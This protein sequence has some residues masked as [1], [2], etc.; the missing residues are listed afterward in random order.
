MM[1]PL[2]RGVSV[3]DKPAAEYEALLDIR[4]PKLVTIPVSAPYA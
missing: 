2:K 3:I 1:E 4:E